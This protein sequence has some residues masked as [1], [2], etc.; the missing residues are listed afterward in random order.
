MRQLRGRSRPMRAEKRAKK[1]RA[2][3]EEVSQ[4]SGGG[5]TWSDRL[6]GTNT[7]Q[8]AGCSAEHTQCLLVLEPEEE[9]KRGHI[10][11]KE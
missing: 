1:R 11:L 6:A 8:R 5:L 2:E 10:T 3:W 7:P 4:A 9:I